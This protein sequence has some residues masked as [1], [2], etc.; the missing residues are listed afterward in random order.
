MKKIVKVLIVGS[1][2]F[3]DYDYF[4]EKLYKVLAK[5]FEENYQIF[6]REQEINTTDVFAVRFAKENNCKLERCKIKWD[7][8]GKSA[9]YEQVKIL[10]FGIEDN[11]GSCD[12]IIFFQKKKD[13]KADREF[14]NLVKDI[15]T[16][17][18]GFTEDGYWEPNINT[19]TQTK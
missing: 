17:M 7:K 3:E 14:I 12:E 2:N 5:Y 9:W 8:Y 1:K 18:F 13:K 16:G 19:F 10:G 4:E 11:I 15:Y 6:I